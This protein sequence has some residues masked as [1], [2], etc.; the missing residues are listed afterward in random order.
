LSFW[1]R[2][3][4]GLTKLEKSPKLGHPL[5]ML[6]GSTLVMFVGWCLCGV[7]DNYRNYLLIVLYS[8]FALLTL[9]L[10]FW[11]L[12]SFLRQK[13]KKIFFARL[14]ASHQPLMAGIILAL[15][16]SFFHSAIWE[17]GQMDVWLFGSTDYLSWSMCADYWL[18]LADPVALNLSYNVELMTWD[19]IGSHM[20]LAMW[21]LASGKTALFAISG[22]MIAMVI[23]VGLSIQSLMKRFFDLGFLSRLVI[24]LSA[25]GGIFFNYLIFKGAVG[26]LVSITAYLLALKE[27][28]SW[29]GQPN[30]K[31]VSRFFIPIFS[32]FLAYQGAFVAFVFFLGLS[33]IVSYF[34]H[35]EVIKPWPRRAWAAFS[36]GLKPILVTVLVSFIMSPFLTWHLYIRSYQ[37]AFSVS[38]WKISFLSPWLLSGL[39]VYKPDFFLKM[40][41][42]VAIFWYLPFFALL[43]FRLSS[44]Q[45]F[46]SARDTV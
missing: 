4:L 45:V 3:A 10:L 23:W 13:D 7:V 2:L 36:G 1:G 37:T 39:P 18:G 41:D 21:A 5:T 34:C 46:S 17:S 44:Q 27:I 22:F 30:K 9:E 33:A 42:Q 43:R 20:L 24:S 12:P 28:L 8:G 38:G 32:I 31:E 11:R 26:H 29:R 14:I 25:I 6:T 16:F 15:I 19:S 35:Q 40:T